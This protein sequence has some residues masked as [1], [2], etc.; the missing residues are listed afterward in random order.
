M[1]IGLIPISE[2]ISFYQINPKYEILF[3]N[4][5]LKYAHHIPYQYGTK[6]NFS[7]N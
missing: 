6:E 3:K 1:K 4:D 5:G 7:K 2:F